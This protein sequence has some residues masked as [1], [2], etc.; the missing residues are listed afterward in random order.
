MPSDNAARTEV[1]GTTAGSTVSI[2]GAKTTG[3]AGSTRVRYQSPP[4]GGANARDEEL[5]RLQLENIQ[6]K[7]RLEIQAQEREQNSRGSDTEEE[8][9]AYN[10]L[11]SVSNL[12][13]L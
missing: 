4:K 3:E 11:G 9:W 8:V 5:A 6:M 7:I 13:R 12:E 10:N 1:T 2:P